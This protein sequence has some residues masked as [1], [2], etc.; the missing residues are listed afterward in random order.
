MKL[1]EKLLHMRLRALAVAL[2]LCLLVAAALSWVHSH[3]RFPNDVTPSSPEEEMRAAPQDW[4][5]VEHS[6][7]ALAADIRKKDVAMIGLTSTAILVTTVDGQKYFVADRH[8]T[9]ATTL[10]SDALKNEDHGEFKLLWLPDGGVGAKGSS[11][12]LLALDILQALIGLLLPV[13]VIAGIVM[14]MRK[15]SRGARLLLD[16]PELS[17]KDVVGA[18]GAKAALSDVTAYL[19]NPKSFISLGIRPPCG[20]LLTGSPGVGKTM[21]AKALAGET[22]ANFISITGS[23]FSAKYFGAGVKRAQNL[24]A[25]AR[26]NQPSIIWI[27]EADGIGARTNGSGDA[28]ESESNRV[29]NQV[30]AEL[31]GFEKNEGVIVIAATNFPERM[32][33]AMR[34]PGR[35]DR[36]IHVALPDVKERQSLFE[37]YA[38][39]LARV[40]TSV[41]FA[42]L[43]RLTTGMSPASIAFIVFT[44]TEN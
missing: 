40:S 42:Q 27:D 8:A 4:G 14:Y 39:R 7:S 35:F 3:S 36:Q 44:P 26:A 31:D 23:Y 5:R 15:E 17:F 22:G 9:I 29:I 11:A 30:L 24:F 18:H 34:R 28:S 33:D 21:L 43:S 37:N 10:L 2:G 41:D 20:V 38:K 13:A 25:L 12:W 6:V 19:K 16:T 1:L 32:D